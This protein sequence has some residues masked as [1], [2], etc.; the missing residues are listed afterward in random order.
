MRAAC[1]IR[2]AAQGTGRS[3]SASPRSCR[4]PRTAGDR[5]CVDSAGVRAALPAGT[6]T[7]VVSH[8]L[9]A[10]PEAGAHRPGM[11]QRA[12]PRT[13]GRG[14][15]LSLPRLS[16]DARSPRVVTTVPQP[17]P[18]L[19]PRSPVRVLPGPPIVCRRV[20]SGGLLRDSPHAGA[21]PGPAA[22]PCSWVISGPRTSYPSVPRRRPAMGRRHGHAGYGWRP[23][24]TKVPVADRIEAQT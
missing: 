8:R 3:G 21:L 4:Q 23:R 1:H 5:D 7:P 12:A 9:S 17:T 14:F 6:R 22:Q 11:A 13:A 20:W 10:R 19:R 24:A 16:R 2:L 15:D 18:A